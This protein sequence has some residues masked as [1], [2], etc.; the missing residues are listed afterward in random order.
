MEEKPEEEMDAFYAR[1]IKKENLERQFR[2]ERHMRGPKI[3]HSM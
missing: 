1:M 2:K 3:N